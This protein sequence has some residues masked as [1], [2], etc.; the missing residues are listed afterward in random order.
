MLGEQSHILEPSEPVS[1]D[2]SNR[3]VVAGPDEITMEPLALTALENYAES[4]DSYALV[5]LHKGN[6]Q[7]EWYAQDTNPSSLMQSQSMH[8]S[9]VAILIGRAIDDG[10][11]NSIDDPISEYIPQWSGDPRGEITIYE[12]MIMSSGLARHDFT[13]N[14]FTNDFRWLYSGNSQEYVLQ[15]RLAD[16]QAGTRFEYNDINAELLGT[17]LENATGQRYAE[18]LEKVLWGPLGGTDGKVWLDSEFGDAHT[19][20]CLMATARDWARIGQMMLNRGEINGQRVVSEEWIAKMI[21]PSPVS[22]WYG[23]QTWLAYEQDLNPRSDN[24]TAMDAYARRDPFLA[25]DVYYFSG[26]GAQRV[27]IVPSHELVIVRLGPA[28][29]PEPLKPGW[30]NAF[31]VNSAI[32]GISEFIQN[33]GLNNR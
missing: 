1:S 33:N 29:G 21:E 5:V 3:L 4:F 10:Y 8:K 32:I 12:L 2:H 9:V 20:C 19:S 6:I 13:L 14:P 31:L 24:P 7:T 26:R 30:D 22:K 25:A 17:I 28:L 15:T 18:Y 11:I 27:Y 16:W 23:L